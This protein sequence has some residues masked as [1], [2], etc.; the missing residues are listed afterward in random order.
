MKK[1]LLSMLL[2]VC[3]VV[4]MLPVQVFAADYTNTEDVYW[5]GNTLRIKADTSL[6]EDNMYDLFVEHFETTPF[7]CPDGHTLCKIAVPGF[8]VDNSEGIADDDTT[9][10]AYK[11][12]E[13]SI[14]FCSGHEY[15][16]TFIKRWQPT[17]SSQTITIEIYYEIEISI[18]GCDNGFVTYN[19]GTYYDGDIIEVTYGTAMS[20]GDVDGFGSK[21]ESTGVALQPTSSGTLYVTYSEAK[22]SVAVESNNG[23]SVT[24]IAGDHAAGASVTFTATPDATYYIDSIL[25]DG[26]EQVSANGF[27]EDRSYTVSFTV[28]QDAEHEVVVTFAEKKVVAADAE[29]G[30]NFGIKATDLTS[31]QLNALKQAIFDAAVDAD[32]SLPE[33]LVWDD[34]TYTYYPWYSTA[35][36]GSDYSDDPYDL[37]IERQDASILGIGWNFR[38]FGERGDGCVEKVLLTWSGDEQMPAASKEVYITLSESR[39]PVVAHDISLTKTEGYTYDVVGDLSDLV[40][41]Y[42]EVLDNN[43]NK[44]TDDSS[45]TVEVDDN[46]TVTVTVTKDGA[47][48]LKSNGAIEVG[49]ITAT[50]NEYTVT[51]QNEDGTVLQS[52]QVAY[53][54]TPVYTEETPTK[55]A[56][57]Q[58]TYTFADWDKEIVAVTGDVT[59]TATY[60]TTTNTYTVTWV[61]EDGTVLETDENVPYG[62]TPEYNG[63]APSKAATAQYTY[64]HTGWD[65]DTTDETVS[66]IVA[67]TGNVTY[68]A[69]YAETARTYTVTFKNGDSVLQSGQVAYGQPP[70]YTGETPVK[71]ADDQYTYTFA[72]WSPEIVAVNGAAEYTAQFDRA[73]NQYTVKFVNA[74]GTEL[75]SGL[76][77][78]GETPAYTGETPV[79][80]ADTQYTYTFKG[81]DKDIA[82]VTGNVTYTATYA[83]SARTYT[84]TFKNGDSVLQ[85]GQVAYGQTPAYTGETPVKAADDQYTY[86]FAGWTPAIVPVTGPAEYTATFTQGDAVK[87]TVTW[88]NHDGSVLKSEDVA[89]GSNPTPPATPSKAADAQYTYTFAGW[90]PAVAAVT[91]DVIYTATYTSTVNQYTV[92]FVNADGKELQSGKVAYGEIPAYTGETPV[93]AADARYTYTFAGWDPAVAAVTGDATYTA[94]YTGTVNRYA[95]TFQNEDGTVLQSGQV[96]Y[97]EMPAY[98]GETP[99]KTGDAQ[100]SYTFA[101]WDPAVVAVTGTAIY[102]ARFTQSVNE[103]AVG[104]DTDGNG[105][106]DETDYVPYGTVPTR[107]DPA[108]DYYDF[109]GWT[110][111][112]VA[113]TGEATYAATWKARNDENVNDVADE[114][115]IAYVQVNVSGNGTV[116]LSSDIEDTVITDLGGGK[117]SVFYDTTNE[118]ARTLAVTATPADTGDTAKANYVVSATQNVAIAP[119]GTSTV[120]VEFG[121]VE[122]T[123][124]DSVGAIWLNGYLFDAE[125][126]T[127]LKAKVIEAAIGADANPDAYTVEMSVRGYYVDVANG[128]NALTIAGALDIGQSES[129]RITLNGAD[130]V[131]SVSKTVSIAVKDS[132][133]TLA[134]ETQDVSI[135]AK[136][137]PADVLAQ[138]KAAIKITATDPQTG[139]ETAVAVSDSYLNAT[140][141]AWPEDGGSAPYTVTVKVNASRDYANTAEAAL[142]LTLT[143]TTLFYDVIYMD[144]YTGAALKNGT[145]NVAEHTAMPTILPPDRENYSFAGWD[146]DGDGQADQLPATV[147]SDIT[148]TAVWTNDEVYTITFR[149]DGEQYDV[150]TINLTKNPG[151]V[152]V[153]PAAPDK[154]YAV[155]GGWTNSGVIGQVPTA[156]VVLEATWLADENNNNVDDADETITIEIIGNGK[157]TVNGKSAA[158]SY[159]YDSTQGE[160]LVIV[161]I[162]DTTLGVSKSYVSSIAVDGQEQTLTFGSGLTAFQGTATIRVDSGSP[163]VTVTFADAGFVFNDE[164]LL[165]YYDGMPGVKNE[166]IYNT[167]VAAP[168][169][170]AEDAVADEFTV[171]YKARDKMTHSISVDSLGLESS[172]LTN[173][174][175]GLIGEEIKFDMPELWLD[176]NVEDS[177][178]SEKI[179]NSVSLEQAVTKHLTKEKINGLLDTFNAAGGILNA[180]EAYAAVKADLDAI[181]QAVYSSAMYYEAHTFG[182]NNTDAET[183]TESIKVTYRCDA[184]AIEGQSDITLKDLRASSLVKG[185]NVSVMYKDY[186][187]EELAAVIGAYVTDAA[188]NKIEGAVATSSAIVGDYTFE[189]KGVSDTGYEITF[190]FAGNE[191]YRPSEATF[192]VTVTKAPAKMDLPNVIATYGEDYSVAPTLTLG[193]KYG[194]DKDIVDSLI[195]FYIGLN[196]AELDVDENGVNGLNGEIKLMLTPDLQE[197]LDALLGMAGVDTSDGVD[198]TLSEL[199]EYLTYID[200]GSLDVLTKALDAIAGITENGDISIT[201]GGTMPKDTGAYLYGAVSTNS[202]YDIVYDVGYIVIKPD[203]KRVYLDWNYTDENGVFTWEL[204]QKIDF[205]A[206]AFDDEALTIENAAVTEQIHELF[207]GVD[208]EGNFV[209]ELDAITDAE[210]LGNGAF[211]EL[212]YFLDKF[213][214]E[215]YYAVPIIR[216]IIITP[217]LVDVVFEDANEN[218]RFFFEFDNQSHGVTASVVGP[219]GTDITAN[220]ELTVTYTGIQTNTQSWNSTEAPKHAGAYLVT[221]VYVEKND[222]GDVTAMGVNTAILVIGPTEST[223]T[224]DNVVAEYTGE[225]LNI[226]EQLKIQAGSTVAGHTPDTT[227]ITASIAATSDFSEN[228]WEAVSGVV[229]VDFPGWVDAILLEHAPSIYEGMTPAEFNTKVTGKV[230]SIVDRFEAVLT[231]KGVEAD[232]SGLESQLLA[233]LAEIQSVVDQLSDNV[234]LRFDETD[235]LT[236]NA[237]G[238]Y[239][240]IGVVTDSD[241]YPSMDAGVLLIVPSVEQAE[242]KWNYTDVNGIITRPALDSVDLAASAFDREGAYQADATAEIQYL[243][244]VWTSRARS[245]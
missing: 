186:T 84:V 171:T 240:V 71:A 140:S 205:G 221:A 153:E 66:G 217:N 218:D 116:T 154:D 26:E 216:P 212:A 204:L 235:T 147:E 159:P 45:Y 105:D 244:V 127:G 202:N 182:F 227:V 78:Y 124:A 96:A 68:T 152:V 88:K 94:T 206:T 139:A 15:T 179:A 194:E 112:V 174:L 134:I 113:V 129:F 102:T 123:L 41:P 237:V 52:G 195:T 191:S 107:A 91:G 162:P 176:V 72:G 10:Y 30:Y 76:V 121:Y 128:W 23:G 203:A 43:G 230:P 223:I 236:A 56:D 17:Y 47:S 5:S 48:W 214:N 161:A 100:Y 21:V 50:V 90:D 3:M 130:P 1:R 142:T 226:A 145:F 49:T 238:T 55:P 14:S 95:V 69:T 67:V 37:N 103:Y 39:V 93:K 120:N 125:K 172:L 150:Q 158:T 87:Y 160:D 28:E 180:E 143:D 12:G 157:V 57:D 75:Q 170:S 177:E 168:A 175:K 207:F 82:A 65:N 33:G 198:M 215:V 185:S 197:K 132:R 190:K 77:A 16:G 22:G 146:I 242:L 228:G 133:Q 54:E 199:Q 245:A 86:T 115:E 81:W 109:A 9:L 229:N 46:F 209:A 61:D 131:P 64:T 4:A 201:L 85:S 137:E 79:K 19:G 60:S 25:V 29:I 141:F 135:S 36:Q 8:L 233:A 169:Y 241:H 53:G 219:D 231:E 211:V 114:E 34:L 192:T 63:T 80:A 196:I 44:I 110:P 243:F 148:C 27:N 220:G 35:T 92:R 193:N 225:E 239:L 166:E 99:V 83:E 164:R 178:L 149:V 189:G 111:A 165:N 18:S 58:Y 13:R 181:Y 144:G 234:T 156:N 89:Y 62:T 151:T 101:G 232:L 6:T 106:V 167:I 97:G 104:W 20:V 188:G 200:N 42:V 59:Y 173:L 210:Q 122:M 51:F 119:N 40:K 118:V 183:V 184:Y 224:V 7:V 187:D 11:A 38:Y 213:G 24:D 32:E 138:V 74:D 126:V 222:N 98:T 70:A 108:R 208:D 31:T 163:K 117:Y 155:F 73:V 2:V 136:D